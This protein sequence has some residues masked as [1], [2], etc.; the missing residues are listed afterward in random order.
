MLCSERSGFMEEVLILFA[1]VKQIA[2][3]IEAL[4]P[5]ALA[6]PGDPVGLQVGDPEAVVRKVLVALE[7]DHAVLE[8]ASSGE[9][10]LVVT[11]HPL[12]FE[13][14]GTVDESVPRNALVAAVIRRRVAVYS[15]HTNLDIAPRGVNYVLAEKLGF[16]REGRRVLQVTGHEQLLK[17]VLYLPAGDETRLLE[18]LADAGAGSIGRY[19]HSSFQVSG[20]GTFKPL[21]GS[22]PFIGS[23]GCLEQVEE[24]R[25]E[26]IVPE[27]RRR[28][29][30]KALLKSHPYEEPAYDLFPLALEGEP[31]GLGLFVLLDRPQTLAH[32][33]AHCRERLGQ[34]AVR[35]WAP[36]EP[37][38]KFSRI[39]LCGGSGGSLIE[40]AAAGGAEL[41][42][43][44]D[45]RHHDLE[46]A[47]VYGL[48]LID[49]GHG[50]TEQPVVDYL[51]AYLRSSLREAGLKTAVAAA[52]APPQ[53]RYL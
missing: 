43:S 11:H 13:P 5:K 50:G 31:L 20:T 1:T 36:P 39:A 44:G 49:A 51:A 29:V 40:D 28:A 45:F 3:Y 47:R 19:S 26:T 8:K 17:L 34:T 2:G 32:L 42:I 7:L 33:A 22:T 30:I 37:D 52:A 14:L 6:L 24:V 15:A 10:D 41:F 46:K 16:P 25:L 4:A 48:G 23:R 9:V 38:Q 53:W 21:Q 35:C 12:L 27:S 18:S